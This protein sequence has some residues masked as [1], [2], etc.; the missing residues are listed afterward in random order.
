MVWADA[1]HAPSSTTKT[2]RP[3]S[4]LRIPTPPWQRCRAASSLAAASTPV[5]PRQPH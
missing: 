4:F 5:P 1:A 2:V 3:A